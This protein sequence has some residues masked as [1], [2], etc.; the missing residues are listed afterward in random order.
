MCG[1]HP[2][3]DVEQF[4]CLFHSILSAPTVLG[5]ILTFLNIRWLCLFLS[6][7]NMEPTIDNCFCFPSQH[8][9]FEAK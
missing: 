7:I 2:E 9:I 1:D 4:Y 5:T 3:Q 8:T 6:L